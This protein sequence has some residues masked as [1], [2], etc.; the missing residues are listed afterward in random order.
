MARRN[1]WCLPRI[2]SRNPVTGELKSL[3]DNEQTFLEDDIALIGKNEEE[4]PETL[5]SFIMIPSG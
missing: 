3:S 2:R 5:S 1:P 4:I